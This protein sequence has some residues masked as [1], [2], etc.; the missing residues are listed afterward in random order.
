MA[1][2]SQNST[3]IVAGTVPVDRQCIRNGT[4]V[5]KLVEDFCRVG[6]ATANSG[7][8]FPTQDTTGAQGL[9][10]AQQNTSAINLILARLNETRFATNYGP[11]PVGDHEVAIS[12]TEPL[13]TSNFIIGISFKAKAAAT[14]SS[15]FNWWI[16]EGSQ[17]PTGFTIHFEKGPA[18]AVGLTYAWTVTAPPNTITT[19]PAISGFNPMS[20]AVGATVIIYGSGFT[21]ASEIDFNSTA[22]GTFTVDSDNKITVTVPAGATSGAISVQTGSGTV[23]SSESFTVTP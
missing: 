17:T 11:V 9:Q 18:L 16:V 6:T 5:V 22:A 20:G 21:G 10:L 14:L 1:A 19:G 7:A 3:P 12:W 4:D 23:V 2:N 8:S 13:A 15:A